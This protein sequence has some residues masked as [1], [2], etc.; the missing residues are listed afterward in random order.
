MVWLLVAISIYAIIFV[1]GRAHS[2]YLDRLEER[3]KLP[4]DSATDPRSRM[5]NHSAI[6]GGLDQHVNGKSP[7]LAIVVL[8]LENSSPE[9]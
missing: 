1:G 9:K 2:R 6:F 5:S 3:W 7:F 4:E 8:F